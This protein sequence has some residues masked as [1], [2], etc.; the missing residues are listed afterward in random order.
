MS[1]KKISGKA[2]SLI[3]LLL[4]AGSLLSACDTAS[5]GSSVSESTS[6]TVQTVITVTETS[7]ALTE[8]TETTAEETAEETEPSVTEDA[9]DPESTGDSEDEENRDIGYGSYGFLIGDLRV[10]SQNDISMLIEQEDATVYD[11]NVRKCSWIDA[12]YINKAFDMK[13]SDASYRFLNFYNNDTSV[14]FSG[15][16]AIG[17][18]TTPKGSDLELYITEITIISRNLVIRIL[19]K[20]PSNKD[21]Y[22]ISICG[23][24]YYASKDQLQMADFFLSSLAENPGVDPLE[25]IIESEDHTYYF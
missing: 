2:S 3:A 10:H 14:T 23:R 8:A 12:F 4:A 11:F 16:T 1:H 21:Y 9:E 6:D 25:G 20:Y 15:N 18:W 19:P 7:E 22:D 5:S 17:T 24:G 13:A